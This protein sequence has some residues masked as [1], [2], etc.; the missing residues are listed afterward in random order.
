MIEIIGGN[1]VLWVGFER[2]FVLV[3]L[4]CSDALL[5]C[6]L[7]LCSGL[8]HVRI[9]GSSRP[10]ALKLRGVIDSRPAKL[11]IRFSPFFLGV[12][13]KEVSMN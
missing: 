11:V 12:L 2:L 9:L 10:G 13:I 6:L 4:S 3:M 7:Y 1:L 5:A 8:L